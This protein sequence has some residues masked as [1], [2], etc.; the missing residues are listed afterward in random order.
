MIRVASPH[1]MEGIILYQLSSLILMRI[2]H[3][4]LIFIILIEDYEWQKEIG[5][6]NLTG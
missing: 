2:F 6:V 3:L 5:F 1:V 4:Q